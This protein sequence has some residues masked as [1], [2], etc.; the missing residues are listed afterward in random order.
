MPQGR[1][2]HDNLV[3]ASGTVLSASSEDPSFPAVAI[4]DQLRSET[5]RSK[6][7]YNVVAGRNDKLDLTEATTGDAVATL[8]PGNYATP[9]QYAAE[10]ETQI[11]AAATDNTYTV[12]YD[13]GT[14]L[15]TI[16]RATGSDAFG[17]EWS[18]GA[19]AATSCG[20]DL[21]FDV[22]ADD[23]G[24]TF[25]AGDAA[26]YHSREWL[27]VDLGSAMAVRAGIVIDHNA[28]SGGTF[29]L[30]GNA[31][32]AWDAPSFS[33][34]LAGD[35]EIRIDV[36]SADESYHYWELLI[37]D[38]ANPDG[39]SEVG[40]WFAGPGV[41]PT[42]SYTH[43]LGLN[44]FELSSIDAAE[45][46]AHYQDQKPRR[47]VWS[48][49]WTDEEEA[50]KDVLEAWAEA[51]PVGTCF[52]FSFTATETDTRYVFRPSAMAFGLTAD[53]YWNISQA[54]AEA[55]G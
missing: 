1:I 18:T 33:Q 2:F 21:G 51:T 15:F 6:P 35:A 48:V 17:L 19:S 8:T 23:T 3:Q 38:V 43:D 12:T 31:T 42:H 45:G 34:A 52:F 36:F 7:G 40:I 44:P 22:S 27:K 46:G 32:D 25:Y 20:P 50:D 30:R 10:V 28:G 13:A 41:F 24:A 39:F 11:N 16:A 26:S 53:R 9:A 37:D 4:L 49:S 14:K 47:D 29:T 54:L 5:W 55:L